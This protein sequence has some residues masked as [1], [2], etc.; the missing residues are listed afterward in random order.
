MIRSPL[1]WPSG[2]PGKPDLAL[3]SPEIARASQPPSSLYASAMASISDQEKR[4]LL[5]ASNLFKSLSDA[6]LDAM[7][8]VVR[9]TSVNARKE[10]FHRGDPASQLYIVVRGR[11]KAL[12]S[13]PNGGEIVFN[14][15]GP[16][17][18]LGELAV[19]NNTMRTATVQAIDVCELLSLR[20]ADLFEFL[21]SHPE[22]AIK[23]CRV[24]AGRVSNLSELVADMQFLNLPFRLAKKLVAMGQAYGQEQDDGLRIKLKLS[25]EEW[26]EL[27][28]AT[29]ESINKQFRAWTK[30]GLIHLDRGCIVLARP[31]EMERLASYESV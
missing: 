18:V 30:E 25:Q 21:R 13:S 6:D 12:V 26:G 28:G 11:L 1:R 8:S 20:Q 3:P 5:K 24:L 9:L 2:H 14:I 10:L 19:L 16:G 22:A 29:R 17:E 27:V 31:K 7:V 23:L 4:R 15:V